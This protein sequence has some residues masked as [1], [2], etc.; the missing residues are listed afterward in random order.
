MDK[1]LLCKIPGTVAA[2]LL[3]RGEMVWYEVKKLRQARI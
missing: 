1:I 2:I 3:Q